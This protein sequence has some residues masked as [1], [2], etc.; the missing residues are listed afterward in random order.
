VWLSRNTLFEKKVI[1]RW[2]GRHAADAVKKKNVKGGRG[3]RDR[4]TPRSSGDAHPTRKRPDGGEAKQN[5][6]YAAAGEHA[7]TRQARK[8][9]LRVE[10]ERGE[11]PRKRENRRRHRKSPQNHTPTT[12]TKIISQQKFKKKEGVQWSCG[13]GG[14][15]KEK[16]TEEG[17]AARS[18]QPPLRREARNQKSR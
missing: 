11:G 5:H 14:R 12:N 15:E 10:R 9:K 8:A 18:C 17:D 7:Q 1:S 13:G 3:S 4:P 2:R 6:A 16:E